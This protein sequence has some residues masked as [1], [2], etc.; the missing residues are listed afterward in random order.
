MESR[1]EWLTDLATTFPQSQMCTK[2]I[3]KATADAKR[4]RSQY[5]GK[6]GQCFIGAPQLQ[7]TPK[8]RG[9]PILISNT[10]VP[11]VSTVCKFDVF[12]SPRSRYRTDENPMSFRP[13]KQ[14]PPEKAEGPAL[15]LRSVSR[16]TG[17]PGWEEGIGRRGW[18]SRGKI[19]FLA[20]LPT[21][22][23]CLWNF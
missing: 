20:Q 8:R 7:P 14:K 16:E 9:N 15:R 3:G 10:Y 12:P 23:S 17:G 21:K 6:M 19:L 13:Q 5:L 4:G 22:D 11:G 1:A 2:G 18:G